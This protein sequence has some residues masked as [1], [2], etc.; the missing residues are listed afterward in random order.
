MATDGARVSE[1]VTRF[2]LIRHGET[3]Y[4]RDGRWQGARSDV[5]LNAAGRDQALQVVERLRGW[6]LVAIYT[7]PLRRARETA[8]PL[9]IELGLDPVVIEELREMDHGEWEGKTRSEIL[10]GWEAEHDAFE[11]DPTGVRRPGGESYG[12]LAERVWPVLDRLTELHRGQQI[13]LVTHAGP[14]RLM[15][16]RTLGRPLTEREEFGTENATVFVF[17]R[18][19]EDWRLVDL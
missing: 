5:P 19:D 7:S 1:R 17:D 12:D 3:N 6:P 8:T 13:A 11:A 16:S 4:N 2:V 15:L 14:I 9:A 10:A 18:A